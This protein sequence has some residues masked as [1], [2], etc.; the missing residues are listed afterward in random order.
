MTER[1]LETLHAGWGQS[2]EIS[3]VLFE[4]NT[5]HQHL[6]IFE[7]P[8]FGRVMALDGAIQTTSRDEFVYHEMLAHVPLLSHPDPRRVLIIGGGDGGILREVV[9]HPGLE[10]VVQVEIDAAV[11]ELCKQ[12]FPGHSD[13]AFEHPKAE[14]VIGDGIEFVNQTDRRFD[15]ILSDSTDPMGPGEVL[16]TERF[17]QGVARSL[18]EG[19]IFAAQ[20]GVPFLQLD[21]LQQTHGRLQGLFADSS[22]FMAAVPS[23]VGGSMALAWACQDSALRQ[24]LQL[25]TIAAR[26][27][28]CNLQARYYNPAVHMAAFALPQYIQD[29]CSQT[30]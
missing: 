14:I 22:F 30:S 5:G 18:A 24:G 8:V 13:G 29:A 2:F 4:L 27:K 20:N 10:Q 17:Y 7:N 12:Y 15:V 9:K 3:D 28:R 6:L 23:Y 16:F 26:V 1:F 25:D 11:I 21:E 19:G